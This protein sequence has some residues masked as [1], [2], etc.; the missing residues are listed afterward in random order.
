MD[1]MGYFKG[2][3]SFM[4]EE[5]FFGGIMYIICFKFIGYFIVLFIMVGLLIVDIVIWIFFVVDI[6]WDRNV[7]YRE[8]NDGLIENVYIIKVFNKF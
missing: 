4:F 1:K 8:I 6:I 3:I 7:L 2:L 5:W